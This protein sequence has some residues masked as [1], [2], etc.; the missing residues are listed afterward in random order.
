MTTERAILSRRTVAS[1]VLLL[2]ILGVPLGISGQRLFD[3]EARVRTAEVGFQQANRDAGELLDLRS[4]QE[5]ISLQQRPPQDVIALVNA[6]LAEIGLP[7]KHLR[8]LTPESDGTLD[9]NA[10]SPEARQAN[11]RRQSLRLT[12]ENLNV[13]DLGAFLTRWRRAQTI[14]TVTRI[15]LTH[16]RPGVGTGGTAEDNRYDASILISALYLDGT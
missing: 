12:L 7:A 6:V 14:W 1:C 10:G 16:V 5:R 2:A 13:Q 4:R 3:A 9:G 11:I 15:E 8:S